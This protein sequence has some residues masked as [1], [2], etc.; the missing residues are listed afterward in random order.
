MRANL[1]WLGVVLFLVG[2]AILAFGGTNV[3]TS[4]GT[5]VGLVGAGLVVWAWLRGRA[6]GD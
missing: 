5:T 1:L 2:G 6:P 3:G 4:A